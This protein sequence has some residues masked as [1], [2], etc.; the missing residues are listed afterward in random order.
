MRGLFTLL[1]AAGIFILTCTASF[2]GFLENGEVRFVWDG[3][4]GFSELLSPLPLDLTSGF[5]LQKCGH[6]F[7]FLILTFLLQTKFHSKRF[8]LILAISYAALTEFL[9]LFFSRD[10]RLFDIGIDLIGILIALGAGSLLTVRQ[11]RQTGL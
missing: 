7:A 9:Q 8:I 2:T 5:L 10:G 1:W 6:V 11:S 4:P 3:H